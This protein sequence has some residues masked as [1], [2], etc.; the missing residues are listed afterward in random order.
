MSQVY[1]I[2]QQTCART[3]QKV[4]SISFAAFAKFF[5][6]RRERTSAVRLDCFR[7]SFVETRI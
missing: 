1:D 7:M 6:K 2:A 5:V 3:S 4:V